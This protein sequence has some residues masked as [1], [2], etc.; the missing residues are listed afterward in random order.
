MSILYGFVHLLCILLIVCY[1]FVL[2]LFYYLSAL[3]L[4]HFIFW[5]IFFSLVFPIT[6]IFFY[7]NK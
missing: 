4:F 1:V 7:L 2:F 3:N 6:H 5:N